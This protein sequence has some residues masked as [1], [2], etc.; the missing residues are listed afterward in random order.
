MKKTNSRDRVT[1]TTD[2]NPSI[3][4]QIKLIIRLPSFS[5]SLTKKLRFSFSPLPP[6]MGSLHVGT[7]PISPRSY[8]FLNHMAFSSPWHSYSTTVQGPSSLIASAPAANQYLDIDIDDDEVPLHHSCRRPFAASIA[9]IPRR[10]TRHGAGVSRIRL[11]LQR[12]NEAQFG[13]MSISLLL[14][15]H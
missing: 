13:D 11:R 10:S 14:R 1:C 4:D 6:P 8:P 2:V 15:L 7:C 9:L 12:L 3:E 5:L